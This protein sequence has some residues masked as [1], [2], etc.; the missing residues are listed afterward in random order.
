M[1]EG[2]PD[3]DGAGRVVSAM[4][5]GIFWAMAGPPLFLMMVVRVLGTVI[6]AS[7]FWL[8]EAF[9]N[10]IPSPREAFT[11][12]TCGFLLRDNCLIAPDT[13]M[14]EGRPTKIALIDAPRFED[15]ACSEER[16]LAAM[17]MRTVAIRLREEP[18][19]RQ[20][21]QRIDPRDPEGRHTADLRFNGSP[22]ESFLKF[23]GLARVYDGAPT[24][25]CSG[26]ILVD[27]PA[28]VT[29]RPQDYESRLQ[30]NGQVSIYKNPYLDRPRQRRV[31]PAERRAMAERQRA[32]VDAAA[33]ANGMVKGPDGHWD[34][35]RKS[36]PSEAAA[37]M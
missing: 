29:A 20:E 28:A 31:T 10:E 6:G 23:H 36:E 3:T 33:R 25:W 2:I 18:P 34:Y 1:S 19:H 5:K 12:G 27:D 7:P 35:P 14:F 9:L 37:S 32:E 22:F 30:P 24:D 11:D 16:A 21:E 4:A 15:A 13:V 26:L 17:A 8:F